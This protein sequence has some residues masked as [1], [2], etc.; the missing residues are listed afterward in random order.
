MAGNTGRRGGVKSSRD[1]EGLAAGLFLLPNLIGFLIFTAIPVGAAFAL[2]FYDYDLLLGAS[3]AGLENFREIFTED[4]V[5]RAALFN[6][7]YF[8]LVSVPLSVVL[9]L[10]TAMLVNQALRGVVAFRSIFLLPYVTVTVALSLVWKWI[11]LPDVG[12]INSALGIVGLEGPAWLTSSTWAMPG[13]IIMSV[14][15]GFG[16]NMVL[17]LAGLQGIPEHLYDAAK[18]DGATSWRRFLHV[19]IP[20]LSPTTFFVVVISVISSFQVFDQ[21]LVMTGG[22]PGTST[23]T[24][25]L[26]IYQKGF[27]SF[28][29]GYA[30]AVALVLFAAIFVFTVVQFIFQRRWVT[31]D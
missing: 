13:L 11:Y 29:M 5:F 9:G 17:F 23:T 22:G 31:Y 8:T 6:T 14:W 7:V 20:L 10:A 15:K 30:A 26:Y 2:A 28:D 12:L 21:A 24:L 27:Q 1:R 4:E 18:V 16:Y 25:V 19:T 3:F